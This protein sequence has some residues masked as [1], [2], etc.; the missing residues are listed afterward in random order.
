M[1]VNGGRRRRKGKE[2]EIEN[3]GKEDSWP[4]DGVFGGVRYVRRMS[5]KGLQ[6]IDNMSLAINKP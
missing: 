5:G 2:K 4:R 6:H 1:G 3:L